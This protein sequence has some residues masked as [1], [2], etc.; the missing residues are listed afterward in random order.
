MQPAVRNADIARSMRR[1]KT[2]DNWS[3]FSPVDCD[4]LQDCSTADFSD[5]YTALEDDATITRLQMPALA[6]WTA[7]AKLQ[8]DLGD[9]SFVYR[10]NISREPPTDTSN[11][12]THNG[13]DRPLQIC[14]GQYQQSQTPLWVHCSMYQTV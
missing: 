9:V 4:M 11:R 12:T 3:L 10:D 2:E 1:V 5:R 14:T 13:R 6:C 7:A 8:M